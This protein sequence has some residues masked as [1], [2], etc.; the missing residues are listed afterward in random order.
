M[1]LN[2]LIFN[3]VD[4]IKEVYGIDVIVPSVLDCDTNIICYTTDNKE[5][6]HYYKQ[7]SDGEVY[8]KEIYG[9]HLCSPSLE[10]LVA[11]DKEMF[12]S[13]FI[14]LH[15][16]T[17][18]NSDLFTPQCLIGVETDYGYI[19]EVVRVKYFSEVSYFVYT[20]ESLSKEDL[21]DIRNLRYYISDESDE[22]V[23][24]DEYI[25]MFYNVR[26]ISEVKL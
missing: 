15:I 7:G 22:T 17:K 4:E 25:E 8:S 3:N 20:T 21:K 18:D 14:Y 13:V 24:L 5:P 12:Y 23:S 16:T 26:D 10:A 11:S 19:T 9:W 1:N 2:E 6:F